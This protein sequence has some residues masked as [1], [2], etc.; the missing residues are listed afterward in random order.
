MDRM[1]LKDILFTILKSEYLMTTF[2]DSKESYFWQNAYDLFL[3]MLNFSPIASNRRIHRDF[4]SYVRKSSS[5][6]P[7]SNL[8]DRSNSTSDSQIR[9]VKESCTSSEMKVKIERKG[10]S[11]SFITKHESEIEEKSD[12]KS[13]QYI[14]DTQVLVYKH[15][16]PKI[17]ECT[18]F[19]LSDIENDDQVEYAL[20]EEKNLLNYENKEPTLTPESQWYKSKSEAQT[21]EFKTALN[22]F[23]SGNCDKEEK[24]FDKFSSTSPRE[25]TKND[26]SKIFRNSYALYIDLFQQN[27]VADTFTAAKRRRFMRQKT[28][29]SKLDNEEYC[30][31]CRRPFESSF[32][33]FKSTYNCHFCHNKVCKS[34]LSLIK[35]RIPI[36]MLLRKD[37]SKKTVCKNASKF[38]L[39]IR[40]ISL[41]EL[42][43]TNKKLLE[44]VKVKKRLFE[45]Y[46][47]LSESC[48]SSFNYQVNGYQNLLIKGFFLTWGQLDLIFSKNP[49]ENLCKTLK[50]IIIS[51]ISHLRNCPKCNYHPQTCAVC[52]N[53]EGIQE[54]GIG[55]IER[56][57]KCYCPAHKECMK[58]HLSQ[59]QCIN[60]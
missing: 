36:E 60:I 54:I 48:I 13:I 5:H 2:Y 26:H 45:V 30:A 10:T 34:C 16:F 12:P 58:D 4:K 52:L 3:I 17:N 55:S 59:N 27:I 33:F 50:G 51:M 38:L 18:E 29:G 39:S 24:K 41:K 9:F 6:S 28:E 14:E 56:C 1:L 49:E 32:W 47:L 53:Q 35:H 46:N 43:V 37:F 11:K 44:F 20:S 40:F 25:T 8:K 19:K 15:Q 31:E 22:T 21:L 57:K 23:L 7:A 42:F